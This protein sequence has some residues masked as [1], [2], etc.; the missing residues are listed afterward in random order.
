MK[1][2]KNNE[3]D[4]TSMEDGLLRCYYSERGCF[5]IPVRMIVEK[6]TSIPK[7]GEPAEVE[8]IMLCREHSTAYV[9]KD[10]LIDQVFVSDEVLKSFEEMGS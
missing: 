5:K 2:D 1:R 7:E 3:H 9:P 8:A 4:A 10:V 6:P